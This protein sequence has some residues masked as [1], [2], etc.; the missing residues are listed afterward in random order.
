MEINQACEES[1]VY[2]LNSSSLLRKVSSTELS[3]L[4]AVRPVRK[5]VVGNPDKSCHLLCFCTIGVASGL[6]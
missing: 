6:C 1:V 5:A 3:A 4:A 2:L